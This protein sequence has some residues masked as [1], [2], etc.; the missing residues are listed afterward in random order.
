MINIIRLDP[1][2]MLNSYLSEK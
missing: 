1:H 2:M